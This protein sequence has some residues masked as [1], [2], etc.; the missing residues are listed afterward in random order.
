MAKDLKPMTLEELKE[1]ESSIDEA[2]CV[3]S[4]VGIRGE[5]EREKA[6]VRERIAPME[7]LLDY[8]SES[9]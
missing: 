2:L 6:A 9:R 1:Y 3:A 5:L 4:G 8:S 7:S